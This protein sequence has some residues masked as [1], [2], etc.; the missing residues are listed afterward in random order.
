MNAKQRRKYLRRSR[1]C[2]RDG[3]STRI[4]I[5]NQQSSAMRRSHYC[6]EHQ[7]PSIAE[8]FASKQESTN[9]ADRLGK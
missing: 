7:I 1:P 6:T 3:C 5:I 9:Y 4:R 8:R 2:L